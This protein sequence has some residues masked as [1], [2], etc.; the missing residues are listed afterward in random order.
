MKLHIAVAAAAALS[1]LTFGARAE[2]FPDK[3]ITIVA[4][5]PAGSTRAWWRPSFPSSSVFP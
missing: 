5:F 4:P 1:V 3:P 2:G